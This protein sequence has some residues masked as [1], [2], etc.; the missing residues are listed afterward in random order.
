MWTYNQTNE[1]YHYGILGMKWGVQRHQSKLDS[2]KKKIKK[3]EEKRA[4]VMN[5]QG[6]TSNKY[7]T[8]SKSL[9]ITKQKAKIEKAKINNDDVAITNA[10]EDLKVAK[11]IKKYGASYP[12]GA[13]ANDIRAVFGNKLPLE[14]VHALSAKE[15]SQL[16]RKDTV[17]N[18]TKKAL[19]V[20]GPLAV[21][22]AIAQAS[23]RSRTGKYGKMKMG[24]FTNG[25]NFK[26][27][28]VV[29]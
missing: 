26:P 11:N 20:I 22:A 9:Y 13:N 2:L 12:T 21:S 1:L 6:V 8:M 18:V 29:Y 17:K 3:G 7:R 27:G 23:Y 15:Y 25:F 19:A 28:W 4:D 16:S 5:K 10:K 14:T 24:M